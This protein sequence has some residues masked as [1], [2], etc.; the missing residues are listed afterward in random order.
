MP[1]FRV[2]IVIVVALGLLFSSA[3]AQSFV[4]EPARRTPVIYDLDVVVVGGGL[5]GVGAALGAARNGAKT[6]LI[7]R[8]GHLGGWLRGT[9]LGSNLAISA[10]EWR[11]ALNEGVLMDLTRLTV[12]SG[13][14]KQDHPSVEKVL[15]RGSLSATNQ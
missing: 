14:S 15:E 12:E 13:M 1:R 4:D 6:L 9:G 5:S 2:L 10:P 7:E 8:N 3:A 11:P